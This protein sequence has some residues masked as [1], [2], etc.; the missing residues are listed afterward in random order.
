[1]CSGSELRVTDVQ[2]LGTWSFSF[3]S[4]T[5]TVLSLGHPTLLRLMTSKQHGAVQQMRMSV[6]IE[7]TLSS[8]Y[9]HIS[10]HAERRSAEHLPHAL[11][12]R[13]HRAAHELPVAQL[14][15][16]LQL[17][18]PPQLPPPS[19]PAVFSAAPRCRRRIAQRRRHA[20]LNCHPPP[21]PQP[22]PVTPRPMTTAAS[23]PPPAPPPPPRA[24]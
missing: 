22:P 15:P 12:G 24:L 4:T 20:P 14:L 5:R 21:R 23:S 2:I 19:P 8:N 11:D 13:A 7:A 17:H 16:L 18:A 9:T 6:R 1:M 3:L 10:R